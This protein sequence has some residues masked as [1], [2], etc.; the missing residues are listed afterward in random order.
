MPTYAAE[1]N[2]F[3]NLNSQEKFE[4]NSPTD[5]DTYTQIHT[6]AVLYND[7]DL[8]PDTNYKLCT[9]SEA[10]L[11]KHGVGNAVFGT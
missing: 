9:P 7:T 10:L 5:N 1:A 4:P 3:D 6:P 8:S 2:S 11:G